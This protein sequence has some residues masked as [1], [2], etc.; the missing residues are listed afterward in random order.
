MCPRPFLRVIFAQDDLAEIGGVRIYDD[1][2]GRLAVF[3]MDIEVVI[4]H[5]FIPKKE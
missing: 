5:S 4:T 3:N 2:L 1:C